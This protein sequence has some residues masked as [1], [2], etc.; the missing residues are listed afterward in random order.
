[1]LSFFEKIAFLCTHFGDKRT[2]GQT[3]GQTDGHHRRIKAILAV[4]SGALTTQVA[5]I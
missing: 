5:S 1:L 4:A 3:D 2:N